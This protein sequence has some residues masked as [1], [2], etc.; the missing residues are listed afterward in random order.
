MGKGNRKLRT[1]IVSSLL[2]N[3]ISSIVAKSI[4]LS[5]F[6]V[7]F[8]VIEG[9]YLVLLVP[10]LVYVWNWR[11]M[12]FEIFILVHIIEEGLGTW[13]WYSKIDERLYLGGLPLNSL[14]HLS[15]LTMDLKVDTVLSVMESY[16][17]NSSTLAG[18]PISPEQWKV[19][20]D[21][22]NLLL[23]LHRKR[24]S[25]TNNYSHT[26]SFLLP[27]KYCMMVLIGSRNNW[28]TS[29][30]SIVIVNLASV[31]APL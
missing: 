20:P 6:C 21:P 12:A 25:S 14:N 5:I 18:K 10:L 15:V 9:Y 29:G 26:T 2:T 3:V 1:E 16:E 11:S 4:L 17:L 19:W 24:M 23:I 27:T 7:A 28:V 30:R 22:H 13:K 8:A 31:A